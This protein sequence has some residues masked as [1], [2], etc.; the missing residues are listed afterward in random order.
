MGYNDTYYH[1]SN[2]DIYL[3]MMFLALN[4]TIGMIRSGNMQDIRSYTVGDK[5]FDSFIITSGIVGTWINATAFSVMI[6]Q[7]HRTGLYFILPS[8]GN[9][10][11][12][13]V[14]AYVIAPRMHEFLKNI[15]VAE[16][17]GEL[18]GPRIRVISAISGLI[19]A[20]GRIAIQF[21]FIIPL[22]KVAFQMSS[23]YA[24][25]ACAIIMIS[26][27]AFGG[28]KA[29]TFTDI[30]Q[31]VSFAVV[32]P[33]V[34]LYIWDKLDA[35]PHIVINAIST[36]DNYDFHKVFNIKDARLWDSILFFAFSWNM[37]GPAPMPL[38]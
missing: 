1:M 37:A 19:P 3:I 30:V 32:V 2:F 11:M 34:A 9:A 24:T 21:V 6:S 12:F 35:N 7:V 29:V 26:Y 8:I 14:F 20:I 13:M 15:T 33:M 16:A 25:I 22:F 36:S 31:F 27:S 4:F 18:F 17:M 23:T 28:I 38:P 5:K 10:L